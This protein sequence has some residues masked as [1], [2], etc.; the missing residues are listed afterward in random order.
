MIDNYLENVNTLPEQVEINKQDIKNLKLYIQEAYKCILPL[1]PEPQSVSLNSTNAPSGTNKGWLVDTQGNLF[2]IVGNEYIGQELLVIVYYTNIKG[3]DGVSITRVEEVSNEIVGSQ[4][5]TTIRI[6]FSN[7]TTDDI[8]V[9]AE[10]G[11]N[12]KFISIDL[13]SAETVNG[14]ITQEQLNLLKENDS[15]YIITNYN[16]HKEKYYLNTQASENGFLTYI[17]IE[18]ENRNV[19]IKALTITES[20]LSWVITNANIG[21]KTL[22]QHII[23]FSGFNYGAHTMAVIINDSPN[24][25][26]NTMLKDFIIAVRKYPVNGYAYN[27]DEGNLLPYRLEAGSGNNAD[28]YYIRYFVLNKTTETIVIDGTSHTIITNVDFNQNTAEVNTS[29]FDFKIHSDTVTEL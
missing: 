1:D 7:N 3:Q 5:L 4:T 11:K 23:L 25:F 20:A 21:G 27:Q 9:Y 28:K 13:V 17:H 29:L 10:N 6:Y 2:K 8:K 12:I 16:G 15:N 22:Y 26:T 19:E 24:I 18:N 14:T